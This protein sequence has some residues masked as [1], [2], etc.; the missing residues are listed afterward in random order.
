MKSL[1]SLILSVFLLFSMIA[2]AQE[3][4]N[5][6]VYGLKYDM[7]GHIG[8]DIGGL[9]PNNIYTGIQGTIPYNSKNSE[10]Y[11]NCVFGYGNNFLLHTKFILT[12]IIG[13]HTN[14]YFDTVNIKTVNMGCGFTMLKSGIG[15]GCSYTNGELFSVKIAFYSCKEKGK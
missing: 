4:H 2:S 10:F 1:R 8:M 13:L 6:T 3:E 9:K 11:M 14:D 15:I 12:G 5:Y 7:R